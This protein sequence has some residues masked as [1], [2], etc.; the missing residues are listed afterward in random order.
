MLKN[1]N[2]EI[3][4]KIIRYIPDTEKCV[5]DIKIATGSIIEGA[6]IS[7]GRGLVK[8][9]IANIPDK[10]VRQ[11]DTLTV[12]AAGQATLSVMPIDNNPIEVNGVSQ[13]HTTGQLV[14]CEGAVE[15]NTVTVAYYYNVPGRDW[16]NEQAIFVK[17]DHAEYEG[18]N[19]YQYNSKR[20]WSVLVEMGLVTG[21]II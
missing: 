7:D 3:A 1:T 8:H 14:T 20:L 4:H 21:D 19:D 15:G 9:R 2:V 17:E 18:L 6:F 16:F 13:D 10:A 11:V 12:D 5:I